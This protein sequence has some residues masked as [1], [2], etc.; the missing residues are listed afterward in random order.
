MLGRTREF[1]SGWT[2]FLV[3]G[4]SLTYD[5]TLAAVFSLASRREIVFFPVL[6][7]TTPPVAAAAVFSL[8]GRRFEH[9]MT[10]GFQIVWQRLS[11][12]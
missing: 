5:F 1:V 2:S 4:T 11:L 10:N 7:A 12:F 9:A 6:A 8:T 3:L